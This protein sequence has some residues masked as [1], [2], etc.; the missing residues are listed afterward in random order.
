MIDWVTLEGFQKH[1]N[2]TFRLGPVTTLVGPTGSGKSSL[3]R[4]LYWLCFNKPDGDHFVRHGSKLCTVTASIDGRILSRSKGK[5]VNSYTLD[6]VEY[7]ALG[8]GSVPQAVSEFLRTDPINFAR[9]AEPYFWFS[10]T[11]G[12]VSR[13][14]NELVDLSLIDDSLAFA[15]KSVAKAKEDRQEAQN[16][17]RMHQEAIQNLNW[18]DRTRKALD[19]LESLLGAL[20]VVH[21][22]RARLRAL[23]EE[24]EARSGPMGKVPDLSRLGTT[25]GMLESVRN[26]RRELGRLLGSI[27]DHE[28]ALAVEVDRLAEVNRKLEEITVCPACGRPN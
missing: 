18:T 13:S 21:V 3:V 24:I 25:M 27:A 23:L 17:V 14:L 10:G 12:E 22:K 11:Q 7:K 1:Q 28:S 9:Q 16:R 26:R 6:G 20:E 5:G 2:R 15:A 8:R 4:A 19:A